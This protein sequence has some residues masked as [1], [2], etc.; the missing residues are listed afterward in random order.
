[1]ELNLLK[2]FPK[3]FNLDLALVIIF[4]LLCIQTFSYEEKLYP[5]CWGKKRRKHRIHFRCVKT[6][7]K[8]ADFVLI[9]VPTPVT[10]SNH[11]YL[12]TA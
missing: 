12:Y 8:Q 2:H 6:V 9:C 3:D 7:I 10:K 5:K 1:M 11:L 4:T